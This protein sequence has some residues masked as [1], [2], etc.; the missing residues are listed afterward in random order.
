MSHILLVDDD[1]T[2]AKIFSLDCETRSDDIRVSVAENGEQ[3]I[4]SISASQPHVIVLDLRMVKGDGFSVLEHIK[5]AGLEIPV[6]VMTNYKNDS[7]MERCK[8]YGVKNYMVKHE[9][10]MRRIVDTVQAYLPA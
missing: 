8:E 6:V 1:Q 7:Y 4:A 5:K 3:A 2:I 9:H 10:T